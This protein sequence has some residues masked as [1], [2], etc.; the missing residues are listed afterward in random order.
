[1]EKNNWYQKSAEEIFK[2]LDSSEK[3]LGFAE[4][5]SRLSKYGMNELRTSKKISPVI[6]F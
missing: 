5:K 6:K 1:L 4:A 3:G 2:I